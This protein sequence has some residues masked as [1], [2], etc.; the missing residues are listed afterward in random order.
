VREHPLEICPAR[1]DIDVL[2]LHVTFGEVL[3]GRRRVGS[4]I[5]AEDEH[6]QID[7][8]E[9]SLEMPTLPSDRGLIPSVDPILLPAGNA[10]PWTG[11]TGTNTFLLMGAVPALIDA[12]VGDPSHLTAIAEALG[13]AS[14]STI[15][16][17]HGHFDH[18]SG[19]PVIEARWPSVRVVRFP[20]VMQRSGSVE[21]GDTRLRP[22]HTPG[23]SPDHV[24][25]FDETTGD[26]F[27]GDLVRMGGTIVIPASSG[28][29]LR[30]YL[31]SL[32]RVRQLA[33][34]RLLPG[35]GPIV[36]DPPAHIETYLRHRDERERQVVEALRTGART[37]DEIVSRIYDSLAPALLR[38]AA[39]SVLAHLI[40]L[41]EEGRAITT[42]GIW[43]VI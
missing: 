14:L 12:G 25:F 9:V 3:T 34:R 21:A 10:S 26:L 13:S 30:Q 11:P 2:N 6:H 40:K 18:A 7:Y 35:H 19:L 27:C 38:G 36:D 24:C 16:I 22:L 43:R 32:R 42:A 28:G 39:D 8:R 33:P 37:P 15:L 41:E 20:D 23:H 31:E 17:T 4:G 1:A 29:N 5:F